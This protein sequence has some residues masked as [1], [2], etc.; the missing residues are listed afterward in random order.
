MKER[1][2]LFSAPM[3]RAILEDR[4][5]VTRRIIEKPTRFGMLSDLSAV[6]NILPAGAAEWWNLKATDG[7]VGAVKCPYGQP[8][9]RL[10]VRENWIYNGSVFHTGGGKPESYESVIQYPA[11]GEKR[12]VLRPGANLLSPPNQRKQRPDESNKEFNKYLIRFF[13][14]VRPSIHMPRWASRI[15]LEVTGIKVERLQDITEDQAKAE[16]LTALTKDGALIKYG[17]PDRDGL[18][19]TDNDGWP[20]QEWNTSPREA[21]KKLWESINGPGSWELNPW[22]WVISFKRVTP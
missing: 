9:D 21:F 3:I 1:P 15:T 5:T 22:I 4:K 2:I 10:W 19:G 11:D 13:Q 17:I 18:P 20:W 8:G 14:V 12:T 7:I 16:G 6:V